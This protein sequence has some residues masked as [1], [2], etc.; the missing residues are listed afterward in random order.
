MILKARIKTGCKKAYIKKLDGFYEIGVFSFPEKN[1]ANIE[2]VKMIAEYF[3]VSS[4][5]VV[6]KR[7]F[8]S[9]DKVFEVMEKFK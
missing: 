3:G 9:K 6:I 7:G 1:K 5:N 2:A 4:K 8:A